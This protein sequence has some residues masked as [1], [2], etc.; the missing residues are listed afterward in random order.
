MCL[1]VSIHSDNLVTDHSVVPIGNMESLNLSTV[2]N[3]GD[4]CTEGIGVLR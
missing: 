4:D 2:S 1:L 3:T